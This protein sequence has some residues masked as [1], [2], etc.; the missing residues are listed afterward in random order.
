MLVIFENTNI[1]TKGNK[2]FTLSVT[3][4][5]DVSYLVTQR[6]YNIF[7]DG[8]EIMQYEKN[9]TFGSAAELLS[10]DFTRSRQGKLFVEEFAKKQSG[11]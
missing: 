4:L 5:G 3:Q 6:T 7:R 10:G 8:R 1:N 2:K 9:S 11:I